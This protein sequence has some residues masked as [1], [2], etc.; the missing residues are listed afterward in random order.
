V[1]VHILL[2]DVPQAACL[3]NAGSGNYSG[4]SVELWRHI[5]AVQGWVSGADW[6]FSCLADVESLLR[7]LADPHGRC[8]LGATGGAQ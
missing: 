8:S 7:D 5:A 4:F 3:N 6:T 1:P 2:Y